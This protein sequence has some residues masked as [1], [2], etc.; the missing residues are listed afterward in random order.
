MSKDLRQEF[1]HPGAAVGD[2]SE[3]EPA[4]CPAALSAPG[5]RAV[6]GRAGLA[7]LLLA[8][9]GLRLPRLDQPI[10]ENYVGRQVP[11]AM[12]ARNL[13]RGSGFLR[14]QLDTGPFPNLF[15]VEPPLYQA[16]VV[17]LRRITG[18]PLEGCGRI[19]S[20]LGWTLAAWG[21]FGLI[22]RREGTGTGLLGVA[23][24][25]LLPVGLRYGRA[26]QPDSLMLGGVVAGLACRDAAARGGAR[27]AGAAG[28][29]LLAVGIAVKVTAALWCAPLL[30]VVETRPRRAAVVLAM[31]IVPAL[32]W[33]LH[34]GA[35]L[36][37]GGGSQ[38]AADNQAIWLRAVQSAA[39][40]RWDFLATAA[41][42]LLA[43]CFTPLGFVLSVVGLIGVSRR[44]ALLLV[45][46][47]AAAGMLLVLAGKAHHEY[48][49]IV[50]APPLAWA[51][52]RAVGS[53]CQRI[54][55]AR[56]DRRAG[57]CYLA[58]VLTILVLGGLSLMQ[59]RGTWR[60]PRE[61]SPLI[62]AGAEVR[63]IVPRGALLVAPEALLYAAD[64]RG[65][66]LETGLDA[67]RR[68][69]GEWRGRLEDE[70]D[71]LGLVEFY[72]GRGARYF[73]DLT[74][75][76]G[77]PGRRGL[78]EEV[79]RRYHVLRDRPGLLIAELTPAR[80]ADDGR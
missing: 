56:D 51:A 69:A 42:Y 13:A 1:R 50:L 19:L 44:P 20:A 25:A 38:A 72:R 73:A 11:T 68:A 37:H 70:D 74:E 3:P 17:G 34:A 63:G 29:A 6:S 57:W 9:L 41:R 28:L 4:P 8:T 32:L 67:S 66:R 15:L 36:R 35:L 76:G 14:P 31:A 26:F 59:T 58:G 16:A 30:L 61:W 54:A 5:G 65:C 40:L 53:G 10:V 77:D 71:P 27:L 21:L 12:V 7:I 78:R 64:R 24:F 23:V 39:W 52:A 49:W 2:H 75:P 46:A 33:Y 45:W 43:R 62:A 79:R 60:T 55:E 18:W 80:R 48:Y 47:A 22:Q